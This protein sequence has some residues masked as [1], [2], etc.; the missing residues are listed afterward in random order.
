MALN[1]FT[2]NFSENTFNPTIDFIITLK[3]A[4]GKV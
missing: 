2:M 3:T 4:D 1:S